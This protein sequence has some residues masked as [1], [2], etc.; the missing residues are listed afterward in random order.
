MTTD[1][2]LDA[3]RAYAADK[4]RP[5]VVTVGGEGV[6]AYYALDLIDAVQRRDDALA[7]VL[8][9]PERPWDE[10]RADDVEA[11]TARAYNSA[12][13]AARAAITAHLAPAATPTTEETR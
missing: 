11:R 2:D 13:A 10:A 8:A 6:L 7:A 5:G 1:I 4:L 9:L 3:I 12:L